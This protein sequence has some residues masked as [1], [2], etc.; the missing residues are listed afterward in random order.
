VV[1]SEDTWAA[2]GGSWATTTKWY[3]TWEW[4]QYLTCEQCGG[5]LG[6]SVQSM[7][8]F[9]HPALCGSCAWAHQQV[10]APSPDLDI[11]V[12][13]ILD[14]IFDSFADPANRDIPR[15]N[16]YAWEGED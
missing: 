3:H 7:I 10:T 4:P 8:H 2:M 5:G 15:L 13:D 12:G 11:P 14:W 9:D 16:F 1:W 6:Y